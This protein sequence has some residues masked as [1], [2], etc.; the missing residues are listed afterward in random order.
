[1]SLPTPAQTSLM[2][3]SLWASLTFMAALITSLGLLQ[4]LVMVAIGETDRQN[5]KRVVSLL[6]GV[7]LLMTLSLLTSRPTPRVDAETKT[8]S[9]QQAEAE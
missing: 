2:G 7:V 1:M 9:T 4:R 6:C 3:A 8:A 5:L